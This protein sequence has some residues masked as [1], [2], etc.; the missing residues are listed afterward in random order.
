MQ[1]RSV[2]RPLQLQL[3]ESQ[4]ATARHIDIEHPGQIGYN[5][6]Q[7]QSMQPHHQ[8]IDATRCQIDGG[9]RQQ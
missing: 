2:R 1:S 8:R 7:L 6:P 5:A 4:T 3:F 9:T